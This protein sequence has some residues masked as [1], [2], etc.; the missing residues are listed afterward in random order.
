MHKVNNVK[1]STK[2][3]DRFVNCK[4]QLYNKKNISLQINEHSGYNRKCKCNYNNKYV[5][6]CKFINQKQR[7]NYVISNQGYNYIRLNTMSTMNSMNYIHY[8]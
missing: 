4:Q 2:D 7:D 5:N 1:I 6:V 8:M 3:L